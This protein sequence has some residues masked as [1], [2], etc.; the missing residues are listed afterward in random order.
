M[1]EK[2]AQIGKGVSFRQSTL[3]LLPSWW[4]DTLA[5]PTPCP[6]PCLFH[7][8]GAVRNSTATI[9]PSRMRSHRE[10]KWRLWHCCTAFVSPKPLRLGGF[11]G[12]A[13]AS[14]KTSGPLTE[15]RGKTWLILAAPT[16]K[17]SGR[18]IA[19]PSWQHGSQNSSLGR[20]RASREDVQRLFAG[21]TP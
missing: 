5:Q 13:P 10:T 18:I 21:T 17:P 2:G 3:D 11:R 9:R 4:F 16:P 19:T 7:Q 8:K 6:L 20:V 1:R 12:S 14:L 15:G